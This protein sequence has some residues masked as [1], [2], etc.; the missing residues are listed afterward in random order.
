M[1][2]NCYE[3]PY[4]IDTGINFHLNCQGPAIFTDD[5]PI[6]A[7]VFKPRHPFGSDCPGC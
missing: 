5:D 6:A 4:L 2:I 3:D 1:I 7:I